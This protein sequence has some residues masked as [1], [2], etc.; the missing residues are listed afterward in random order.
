MKK[1]YL[2]LTA[3][4]F[5]VSL[6]PVN[7]ASSFSVSKKKDLQMIVP[8]KV[9]GENVKYSFMPHPVSWQLSLENISKEKAARKPDGA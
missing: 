7:G 9:T 8:G 3:L 6:F 5:S 4:I 2:F 1:V